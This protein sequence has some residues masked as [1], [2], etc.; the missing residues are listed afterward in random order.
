MNAND[1]ERTLEKRENRRNLTAA[2]RLAFNILAD[3]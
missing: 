1:H 3:G 2:I